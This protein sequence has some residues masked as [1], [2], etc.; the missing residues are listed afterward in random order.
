MFLFISIIRD[1]AKCINCRVQ[2]KFFP[3]FLWLKKG[4][5]MVETVLAKLI[6]QCQP[7]GQREKK[8]GNKD[9]EME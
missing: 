1:V 9:R 4:R 7:E 5:K 3:V 2:L 6:V 8:E